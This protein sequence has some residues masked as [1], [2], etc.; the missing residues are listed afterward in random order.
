MTNNHPHFP[1]ARDLQGQ[2]PQAALSVFA[3]EGAQVRVVTRNGEPWFVLADV[4][5]VLGMGN[6]SQAATRLDDDE[7]HTLTRNEGANFPGLGNGGALPTLISE[8]G[9]YRLVM[10]SE[11]PAA[12]TFQKWVTGEVLPAIRKTGSYSAA[13]Q[14][15][16]P[17]PSMTRSE[18]I[19]RALL[20]SQEVIREHVERI[21]SLEASN[22]AL[23]EDSKALDNLS[24]AEGSVN[25]QTAGR[26]LQQRPNKF[27]QDIAAR[28]LIWRPQGSA[29]YLAYSHVIQRGLMEHKVS[30]IIMPDGTERV[31]TQVLVTAKGL[32]YL[33]KLFAAEKATHH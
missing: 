18:L 4:C 1:N 11:K 20:E 12:K 23:L 14:P 10:R 19:A 29:S 30:T 3:F 31:R 27:I 28:G 25:L 9:L 24:R 21:Q 5:R 7:K 6:P 26:L 17:Q 2:P 33:A 15:A 32:T 22:A 13:P 16:A 8:A